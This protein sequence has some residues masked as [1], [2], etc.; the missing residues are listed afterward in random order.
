MKKCL[1]IVSL[2]MLIVTISCKQDIKNVVV[3]P[4]SVLLNDI[5]VGGELMAR[6]MKNFDRLEE[7]NY[8]PHKVYWSEEESGYWP[9]DKEGRTILALTL[10]SQT[11]GRKAQYLDT[12]IAIFPSKVNSK[13]YFGTIY[14]DTVFDEQQLASHGWVLRALCEYYSWKKDP[15]VLQYIN[16][17]VDNLVLPSKGYHTKYPLDTAHRQDQGAHSGTRINKVIGNWIL[18]TDVGCDFIF[19]DGVIQAYS[20]TGR[21]DMKPVIDE[22]IALFRKM[23]L[24]KIKAQTHA[25]LT[26]MRGLLRYYDITGDYSLVETVEKNYELYS[27]LA[28]TENYENYNW[29]GRPQWTEPCAV[30]DSYILAM[31]LWKSTSKLSYIEDA[32]LIYYNA[33]GFEQRNNGGFGTNSCS[34]AHDAHLKVD[35]DEAHWCCTMRGGEGLATVASK[36]YYTEGKAFYFTF[37]ENSTATLRFENDSIVIAQTSLYPYMG[38][39]YFEVLENSLKYSPEVRLMVPKWVKN[40]V[41]TVNGNQQKLITKN[42]FISFVNELKK[43]DFVEYKFQIISGSQELSNK[44]SIPDHLKYFYG[45][46]VLGYYGP[47]EISLPE[48]AQ[49]EPITREIFKVKNTALLVNPVHHLMSEQV[50][51]QNNYSIQILFKK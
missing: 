10:L 20:L 35:V 43:G 42:G 30:I 34:G 17:I 33:M 26:A 16:T 13:G 50:N 37:F 40:P 32:H 3:K 41:V 25:S 44:N 2:I 7:E 46:L 49:F 22:M 11:T 4:E 27:T 9:G 18:S 28:R 48:N 15:K 12:L 47:G 21:A 14:P 19:M 36:S 23:D 5:R 51:K 29:F 6:Q 1:N 24:V 38:K 31:W 39:V 45:P 8:Q